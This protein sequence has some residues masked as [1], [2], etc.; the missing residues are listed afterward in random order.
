MHKYDLKETIESKLLVMNTQLGEILKMK[1]I[2]VTVN[3]QWTQ[4]SIPYN[5]ITNNQHRA[6]FYSQNH[7][8]IVLFNKSE[9]ITQQ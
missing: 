1:K 4:T 9:H 6:V 7:F 8:N 2:Y 3:I 5:R